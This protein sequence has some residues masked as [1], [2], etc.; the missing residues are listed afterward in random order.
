MNDEL[1]ARDPNPPPPGAALLSAVAGSKPV[2]TRA[3][4]RLLAL[5]VAVGLLGP[6]FSLT[7][8]VRADLGFLPVVW[9]VLMAAFWAAG[10]ALPLYAAIVP[11]RGEVLPDTARAG[12]FALGAAAVLLLLG[13]FTT[14][15]APGHTMI[16]AGAFESTWR[17][18]ITFGLRVT[19]PVLLVSLFVLR[20]SLPVGSLPV[21]A[22]VGAGAGALAGLTLHFVCAIGGGLHVGLAH[23]GGVVV[24]AL[25][26]MLTLPRFLN[27]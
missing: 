2:K 5:L 27:S 17:H 26:G 6:V 9:V 23:A 3:P 1:R 10:A 24:G 13:L 21:A 22:A 12:R 25:L 20:R 16:P 15:N 18:C 19:L 14:V 11:P 8:G 7:K 4:A